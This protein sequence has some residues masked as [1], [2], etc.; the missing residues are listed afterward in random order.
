MRILSLTLAVTAA[1][2][3]A[4]CGSNGGPPAAPPTITRAYAPS[5]KT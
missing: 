1:I 4:A 2:G 3:L 5:P